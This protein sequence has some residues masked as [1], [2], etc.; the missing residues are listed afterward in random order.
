MVKVRAIHDFDLS[1]R[2]AIAV[3]RELAQQVIPR[4]AMPRPL[5]RVLGVDCAPSRDGRL[6]AAAV[7]CQAP[8]WEVVESTVV[9]GEPGMPYVT[10]LLSFREAPL[11]LE[12]LGLAFEEPD[13]V[14]VDGAGLAHPRRLGLACHL[15]LHLDVPVVGMAK[16]RL[17]GEHAEPGRQRGASVPL[18]DRGKLLG[19]VVRTRDGVKPL[20]V[21]VGHRIGLRSAVAAVLACHGGFRLPEPVRQADLL[22]K[23]AARA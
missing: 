18:R 19:R 9:S 23:K 12:A 6:F 7:L 21:S 3:Q 4:G 16:T 20:Y 8:S 11:V 14:L 13:L 17:L 5:R 1:P 15:G 22:S 10:G 2:E